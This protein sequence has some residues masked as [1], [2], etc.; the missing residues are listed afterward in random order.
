MSMIGDRSF[1]VS[2]GRFRQEAR[3]DAV[4]IEHKQKGGAVR[5]RHGRRLRAN[6]ARCTAAVLDHDSRLQVCLEQ[7]LNP[8]RDLVGRPARRKRHDEANRFRRPAKSA[9]RNW[10]TTQIRD[11]SASSPIA[12]ELARRHRMTRCAISSPDEQ[13]ARFQSRQ[14]LLPAVMFV[15]DVPLR[16]LWHAL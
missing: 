16:N 15:P 12:T 6:R 5:F 4:G 9:S 13:V 2:K 14:R 7:R 1:S 10:A 3:I 8:P 11:E